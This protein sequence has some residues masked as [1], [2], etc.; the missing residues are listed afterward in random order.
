MRNLFFCIYSKAR[1]CY[2]LLQS[3]EITKQFMMKFIQQLIDFHQRILL[4]DAEYKNGIPL[5]FG[6][7]MVM[8]RYCQQSVCFF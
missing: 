5:L 7:Q 4:A 2:F 1:L 8:M 6:I 3:T